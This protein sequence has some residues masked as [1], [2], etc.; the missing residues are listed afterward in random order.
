M[1]IRMFAVSRYY[2][3]VIMGFGSGIGSLWNQN[4]RLAA[5]INYTGLPN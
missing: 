4:R 2:G 3:V 1:V 5:S